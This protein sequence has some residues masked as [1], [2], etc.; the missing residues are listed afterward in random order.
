M[1]KADKMKRSIIPLLLVGLCLLLATPAWSELYYAGSLGSSS[2]E[3]AFSDDGI[4]SGVFSF[5]DGYAVTGAVGYTLGQTRS[6]I[7]LEAGYRSNDLNSMTIYGDGRYLVDG[8]V[9]ALSLM[10]NGF[11]DL[12]PGRT[13]SPYIGVGVGV[14]NLEADIDGLGSAD[15]TVFAWQLAIGWD[16]S[17]N[18]SLDFNVEYRYFATEDPDFNGL[19]MDYETHNLF[20]GLRL[21]F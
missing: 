5:E 20:V 11:V 19:K 12:A 14:A 10:G 15:D 16:F 7:E 2:V 8:R 17:V 13:F 1:E 18:E 4:D 6:R 21:S 3:D 9:E